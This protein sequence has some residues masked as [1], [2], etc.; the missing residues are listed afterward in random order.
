MV[1]GLEVVQL[2]ELFSGVEGLLSGGSLLLSEGWKNLGVE[3]E[4]RCQQE[5][6]YFIA[7]PALPST[8]TPEIA[9][10]NDT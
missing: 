5:G 10:S 3:K 9:P 6:R 2:S 4:K 1:Y 7:I 8:L